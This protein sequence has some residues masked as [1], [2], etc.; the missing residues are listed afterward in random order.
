MEDRMRYL[1][2]NMEKS[3]GNSSMIRRM[4]EA[5]IA[6]RKE[7]GDEN[8]Y[9]FSLGNP[10]LPPPPQV[11]AALERI[12]SGAGRPFA[13]GYMPNAGYPQ[14]RESLA[15]K[16]SAEQCVNMAA[17]NLVVT[18]GAAGGINVFFH[19]VL[20]PGDEVIAPSPYFVEYD[21]Y[22][23]NH[24]GVLIPAPTCENTFALD[25][26]AIERAITPRTRAVIINSPNNPTGVIYSRAELDE[27]AQVI[28]AA[29]RRN[30]RAIYV[31][32]D[33]PYRFLNFDGVELPGVASCFENAVIIG[34][35]SKNLSLAGERLGYVAVSPKI[36][37]A[38]KLTDALILCNRI[39][40]F[41]NAPALGQQILSSCLDAQVDLEIYRDR[42]AAMA[43][44][45]SAAG[46]EFQ[47]PK[48]A[49]YFFP[50][51]PVPDERVFV[52]ALLAEHVLAVPGRGFGRAGHVRMT[53]CVD[54][55]VIDRAA[56][57]IKRAVERC[58]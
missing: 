51:S 4:F 28:S 8:V 32:A 31:I 17:R 9:D 56:P 16:V 35:F 2:E 15:A 44:A 12:A 25:I 50:K 47:M 10:D 38:D 55:A 29:E 49:F 20:E 52:D 11:K 37:E 27:L 18:C 5:G 45:L 43:A 26:G 57:A 7:F 34:S 58:R 21:F 41:V 19:A 53:F 30:N 48:G 23:A 22:A 33:E 54:R 1:N 39:L 40:G 6:L 13:I 14:L 3:L 24:G 46:I 36:A 42:R